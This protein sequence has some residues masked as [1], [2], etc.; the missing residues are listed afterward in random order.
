MK[1]IVESWRAKTADGSSKVS[2]RIMRTQRNWDKGVEEWRYKRHTD[3]LW[4]WR[5]GFEA[6]HRAA[7]IRTVRGDLQKDAISCTYGGD[8][9][10]G[11]LWIV[12]VT[13]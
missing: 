12:T 2:T 11:I 5:E 3:S 10:R 6:N 4:D 13:E 8:T 7:V 9:I 1:Y